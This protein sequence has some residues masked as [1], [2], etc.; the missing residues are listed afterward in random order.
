M[1]HPMPNHPNDGVVRI[2]GQPR[3][4]AE[5]AILNG[6]KEFFQR[7]GVAFEALAPPPESALAH[8]GYGNNCRNE[9]RPDDRG[10]RF[11]VIDR[12]VC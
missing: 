8:D 9:K 3:G 6:G 2:F 10:G 11:E 12:D 4:A 7:G 1:I 5:I